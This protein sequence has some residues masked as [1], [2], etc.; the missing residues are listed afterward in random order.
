MENTITGLKMETYDL[1]DTQYQKKEYTQ[2]IKFERTSYLLC[3]IYFKLG[4]MFC[5]SGHINYCFASLE[6]PT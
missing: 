1:H 4:H 5:T 2:H 6:E 3:L